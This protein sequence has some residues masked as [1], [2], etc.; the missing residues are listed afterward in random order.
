[1]LEED[2]PIFL[3]NTVAGFASSDGCK[4]KGTVYE[5]VGVCDIQPFPK[6][7]EIMSCGVIVRCVGWADEVRVGAGRRMQDILST[8]ELDPITLIDGIIPPICGVADIELK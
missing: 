5:R 7:E 4:F 2:V 8:M 1:M 6:R 3:A